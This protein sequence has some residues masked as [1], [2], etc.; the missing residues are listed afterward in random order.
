MPSQSLEGILHRS[1][2]LA[3]ERRHEWATLEHLLLGLIDDPDA[4]ETLR[5]CDANFDV[6]RNDLVEFLKLAFAANYR[7]DPKPTAGFQRAVLRAGIHAGSDGCDDVTGTDV[8]IAL[9]TETKAHAVYCLR[10]QKLA[11]LDAIVM[12]SSQEKN[13]DTASHTPRP[14]PVKTKADDNPW[15]LL[16]TLYGKP[17][18]PPE[19]PH[20]FELNARNRM[21]W[22]RYITSKEMIGEETRAHLIEAGRHSAEELTP[23]SETELEAVGTAFTERSGGTALLANLTSDRI[24]F[25]GSMFD[26]FYAERFVFPTECDFRNATFSGAAYF[27][28]ATFFSFAHFE[29]ANFSYA[30]FE[31]A[32]F[33]SLARFEN[34]TFSNIANFQSATFSSLAYFENAKFP[35]TALFEN[36]TF[37][38]LAEFRG[39][40]FPD[41]ANFKS[42]TFSLGTFENATFTKTAE[43]ESAKFPGPASFKSAKFSGTARFG[44]AKFS[45]TAFFGSAKFSDAAFFGSATFSGLF[46]TFEN[47]TFSSLATFE[48]ATF[49]SV[50]FTGAVFSQRAYF[51]NVEMNSLTK[52]TDVVFESEPPMFFGAKLH[53]G[54][55]WRGVRWPDPPPDTTKA[56]EFVDAYERLKLEMDRLKKHEDELD[57]FA[58][59]LQ[60][61]RVQLG[62]WRGLPIMIYGALCDYGRNYLRPL[63][64]LGA[65]ALLGAALFATGIDGCFYAPLLAAKCRP[66]IGFSFASVLSVLLGKSLL[67]RPE[68]FLA[69]SDWLKAVSALQSVLGVVLLFLFG[70][71]VRNRFRMK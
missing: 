50:Y 66:A 70:L 13:V 57:F 55:V 28:G 2:T 47:A 4:A 26:F 18:G 34:A 48:S 43:F 64:L 21:A 5:A 16:A 29:N 15:Y 7:Q 56:A 30:D 27:R 14:S 3:R 67:V 20:D 65:T 9:C 60:S 41:H 37:S 54:T 44:S 61:R 19:G 45:S 53:E 52:F 69:L 24:D 33:S 39:A 58:L 62:F 40:T 42:A 38:S 11:K 25:S 59:Q 8:L 46:T 10:K 22:N 12:K 49:S 1:L 23:F 6:L 17:V 35:N 68:A 32:I 31:S 51:I 36:A 71:G 63:V